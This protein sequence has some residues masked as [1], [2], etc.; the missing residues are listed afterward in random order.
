MRMLWKTCPNNTQQ[1]QVLSCDVYMK[2]YTVSDAWC[3]DITILIWFFYIQGSG[4]KHLYIIKLIAHI[5]NS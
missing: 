4:H 1:C 2:I 5:K 3:Y